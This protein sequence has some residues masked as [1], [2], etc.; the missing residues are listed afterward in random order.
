VKDS[1]ILFAHARA[2]DSVTPIIE[3][4]EDSLVAYKDNPRRA[5]WLWE[6]GTLWQ[7]NLAGYVCPAMKKPPALGV[8]YER[9]FFADCCSCET[10]YNYTHWKQLI[11]DYPQ[12][13]RAADAAYELSN[14]ASGGECEGVVSCWINREFE[15]LNSFLRS[16]PNSQHAPDAVRRV[17]R[18]FS[19]AL[20]FR[21][22]S[23]ELFRLDS[24]NIR[25]LIASYD[26]TAARLPPTLRV[27]AYRVLG[28]LWTTWGDEARGAQLYR[29]VAG[30]VVPAGDTVVLRREWDSLVAAL[31]A[32]V[33]PPPPPPPL[34]RYDF[35]FIALD[36]QSDS[37]E[38]QRRFGGPDS[39]SEDANPF[40]K[41][42]TLI[43][44][45]YRGHYTF[46]V[47]FFSGNT[48]MGVAVT[49]SR[50]ETAR[51]LRV[52]D[53]VNRVL[54]LYGQP[55][56]NDGGVYEYTDPEGE[57]LHVVRITVRNG[58]VVEIYVGYLL[59]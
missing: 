28:P 36:A 31:K 43:T 25:P 59:D 49:D 40:D 52:G 24:A 50:F 32:P 30:Q 58:R 39:I 55:S 5:D 48:V 18:A 7:H 33:P 56:S 42:T 51:R 20:T 46:D 6:L 23:H 53:S 34:Q 8:K 2:L 17:N 29:T 9:Y 35:E 26:S 37:A 22:A 57:G 44:W 10:H 41:G 3:A 4:L 16:Y 12:H 54:E 11:H 14:A 27:T 19:I 47:H 15:T 45:H 21:P 38:V 13:A 1:S